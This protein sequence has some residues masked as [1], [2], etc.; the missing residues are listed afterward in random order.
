MKSENDRLNEQIKSLESTLDD[1]KENEF[2]ELQK[3][4]KEFDNLLEANKQE[5]QILRD[6]VDEQKQQLISAYTE[7]ELEQQ[8]KEAQIT[9]YT[10]QIEKLQQ[11][12]RDAQSQMQCANQEY[13]AELNE[14]IASLQSLLNENQQLLE[15]QSSEIEN[16]QSTIDSLNKQIMDLYKSMESHS[17]ELAE[18]D[19]E[20]ELLQTQ[21]DK[22]KADIKKMN[23]N[24]L[25]AE[26][27]A[28]ELDSTLKKKEKEWQKELEAALKQKENEFEQEKCDTQKEKHELEIKNREQL[29]KLKKFAANLKKKNA[30][31]TELEAKFN[32]LVME[33]PIEQ[34]NVQQQVQK[35]ESIPLQQSSNDS[36]LRE[37]ISQLEHEL[38]ESSTMTAKLREEIDHRTAEIENLKLR[39][40][41][42]SQ[43]LDELANNLNAKQAE[44]VG[45]QEKLFELQS[46]KEELAKTAEDLKSK[47]IKIEKCKAIIKEKNKEIRR[48]QELEQAIKNKSSAEVSADELK[49]QLD[50]AQSEKNKINEEFE[51]YRSF[52]ETKLQNSELLVE[53][54]ETENAQLKERI[55][56]LEENICNAEER[57]S[58]LE[59][60]SELLGLQLKEKETQIENTEDE[61]SAR[62]KALVGQDE[63]IE[64]KLK[65]M[66]NERDGLLVTLKDY[67]NQMN[68]WTGKNEELEQRIYELE[69]TRLIEL[70]ED[71]KD[72]L[73]RIEKM[74]GEITRRQQEYDQK[75]AEKQSELNDLENEL[76]NH[77]QNV[78]TERRT[79][80]ENLEKSI[81]ENSM[82]QDQIV[83][84][85][86]SQSSLELSRNELEKEITWVKMQN[87][88]M[89]QDQIEAQELRMQVVHDQTEVDNLHAQNL[90]LVEKHTNELHTLQIQLT[91]VNQARVAA[92]A[93]I[94][95]IAFE[96]ATV[97]DELNRELDGLKM[98]IC[99]DQTE[100]VSLRL[101]NEQMVAD[102]ENELANL[103]SR[104]SELSGFYEQSQRDIAELEGLRLH[105]QQLETEITL[106]RQQI[107][108]LDALQM[109]VGQNITQ[110]QME[111]H[112]LRMQITHD[113]TE[114]ES[115]RHQ[116]QQ[117]NGSHESELAALRQQ[118]AELDS[119]RMQVGQNQTD[120][121]VFIQNENERLQTLLAE[122]EIEIQNYQRQN[123]QLQMSS[124]AMPS[125]PFSSF[126]NSAP[127]SNEVMVLSSKV[128]ELEGRLENTNHEIA[129]AQAR[130]TELQRLCSEKDSEI[131]R[132]QERNHIVPSE[133]VPVAEPI[134]I[135]HQS[136]PLAASFEI[137]APIE[138]TS[139]SGV[140]PTENHGQ[141]IED[142]Q[143]NVSDLEKYVTDLE[144][145]LK[146]ANEEIVKYHADRGNFDKVL[147]TRAKQYEDEV[148][149]LNASV[150]E[151]QTQLTAVQQRN[152]NIEQVEIFTPPPIQQQIP[153]PLQG[154]T[155]QLPTASAFFASPADD[156]PFS[157]INFQTNEPDY[158][159]Q[160]AVVEETIVPKKSYI[161]HP[162]EQRVLSPMNDDWSESAWG[163]DA[164]LEEQHQQQSISQDQVGLNRAAINL[165]LEIDEVKTDRDNIS[166]ELSALQ[167]KYAK[168]MKKLREY[169]SKIDGFELVKSQSRSSFVE[170]NDLDLAIQ[171]ELNNQIK[172]LEQK[173]KE[174]KTE[175][176]KDALEKKKLLS[177]VDVLTAANDRMTEMKDKQDVEIEVCKTKIREL[178]GRL[179]KLNEWGD[180]GAAK[181]GIHDE[182]A[183]RLTETQN[184]NRLLEERIHRLQANAEKDEYEEERDQYFEQFRVL[185]AEKVLLEENITIKNTEIDGLKKKL[186]ALEAQNDDFKATIELLSEESNKIKLHLDQLKDEHKQ[187]ID[188]NANLAEKHSELSEKNATLAKQLDEMNEYNLNSKDVEQ[189][190]QDLMASIQYKDSEIGAFIEKLESQK[191]SFEQ[192]HERLRNELLNNSQ[193]ITEL[194]AE[195]SRLTVENE[196]L[197]KNQ[198]ILPVI[199]QES[200]SSVEDIQ[201]YE[202]I[203]NEL[204]EEKANMEAELQVLN[205][206]VIKNLEIED[207]IKSTVLELDMKNI[208]ISELKNSLQQIKDGQAS[209]TLNAET[210]EQIVDLT[211]QLQA[212]DALYQSNTD[213][214]NSQWQQVVDQKCTE[215]AESWRQ[216]L[217]GKEEEFAAVEND[218]REKILQLEQQSNTSSTTPETQNTPT[219][220]D[221]R[222]IIHES[223]EPKSDDVNADNKNEIIK[224]MQ[225]ALESQEIEIVSLKEQ[226][227]IRSAEYARIA[228]SVDPYATKS[229]SSSIFP[230]INQSEETQPKGNELDL[231]LYM[232]HQRDM[233]C[234]EL[235]E[236]VIHL[237]EERDT[238][239]LKLSN[240]IRQIEEFKRKPGNDGEYFLL[241]FLFKN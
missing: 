134:L 207:R 176:E 18:K 60:H 126:T 232:L 104:I 140:V 186:S 42:K 231:A 129:E 41:E 65:G 4:R 180:E 119:L 190:I 194:R 14:K 148:T 89:T 74:E 163:N 46:V 233:R 52:I 218:L 111:V 70:E 9:S 5:L 39:L 73:N 72:L 155:Q 160:V 192:E 173:L 209:P 31:Y 47:N 61:Y 78:E 211:S 143:R 205:D 157:S 179:E 75:I 2:Q 84:L 121:Q 199:Q 85:R 17:T 189:R 165:Q 87:D 188:E 238:L 217:L 92:E 169:K 215:V 48:L 101:R 120:D 213:L 241:L 226:L 235:T 16:K 8:Q 76:S 105:K 23:Q 122:K 237:L 152:A 81:E 147:A 117:L 66:Q 13:I 142:L 40:T 59:H 167:T 214:L 212:K 136:Q 68:E 62:L 229:T 54:V 106:L 94:E 146:A 56:R 123:L 138:P 200:T 145:K 44:I 34:I 20:I 150:V 86:E 219:S 203:I 95:K 55:A 102:H 128:A 131:A 202:K 27:R 12:L 230:L 162:E 63:I 100:I 168:L 201:K 67:E 90:E 174:V 193:T 24:N 1:T 234:E 228:A 114:I 80:Q 99:E 11:E 151:L 109:N 30:Q 159:G 69:S 139:D 236:E 149:A 182:L 137:P 124:G 118:I 177:R 216:H 45:L 107:T 225:S 206:Q 153:Q 135:S 25:T 187:K 144:H 110:D 240:S 22:N 116:I 103:H 125:D 19:D 210:Q 36:N 77:L 227:A 141:Q 198:T 79:I 113:Q 57:R 132:L 29:E 88:T 6:L 170:P 37:K 98:K 175:Q 181:P 191:R 197:L 35:V 97:K 185:T 83:Q 130:C 222:S 154:N 220:G 71:N 204:R 158:S 208:E 38:N 43:L 196:N 49:L 223:P 184:Q 172:T 33:K 82:L 161:C 178:N 26:R 53:S 96:L 58:S 108:A 171:E 166:A 93:E 195:I 221:S 239:Q 91:E 7:H 115:L 64:E 28:K 156:N 51:N 112:Q 15:Q 127:D 133:S 164:I 10:E 32:A 183:S 224:N 21:I 3:Q 50:Q